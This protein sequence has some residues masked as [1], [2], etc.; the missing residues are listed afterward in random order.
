MKRFYQQ[1][2]IVED[3]IA[4][5][6]LLVMV[7]LIFAA[8]GAR[9]IGSP[10]NWAIDIATALFTW[11]CFFA[12]DVAWRNNR[13][14]AVESLTNALSERGR[15]V[16]RLINLAIIGAF[17]LYVIPTGL[18]LSWVSRERSFQGIPEMSYSWVTMAM[19]V[20]CLVLLATAVV[21]AAEELRF[22]AVAR[23]AVSADRT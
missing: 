16:F 1:I 2:G 9:L 4:R 13:L 17:L 21:K 11:T 20:G 12:A 22:L 8:A 7:G 14:M 10:L 18:W 6:F 5:T 3:W 15:S 23:A 19:P